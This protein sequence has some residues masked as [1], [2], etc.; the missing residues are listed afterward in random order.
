[1]VSES[2]PSLTLGRIK[3]SPFDPAAVKDLKDEVVRSLAAEAC[4]LTR[5]P[6]DR[7]N[8]TIDFRIL[9]LLLKA[10]GDPDVSLGGFSSGVRV[11]SS[12]LPKE[13][14]LRLPEQGNPDEHAE[15]RPDSAGVCRRNC[16][17]VAGLVDKIL[18]VKSYLVMAFLGAIKMRSPEAS[19]QRGSFLDGTNGIL[20]NR[21]TCTRD[22]ERAPIAADLKRVMRKKAR[23]GEKTFA[24]SVD[25]A[26]AHRQIPIDPTYS[27]ARYRQEATCS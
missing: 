6:G 18:E 13:E 19:S 3:E 5:E 25:V 26:E 22:Q 15:D 11:T 24:L 17:S 23:Q 10:F 9:A 14:K 2:P 27:V 7:V 20:V 8:T 12:S 1:M 16:A 4:L 21:R